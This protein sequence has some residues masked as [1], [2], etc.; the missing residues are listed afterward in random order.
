VR[1]DSR[2]TLSAAT[3]LDEYQSQVAYFGR[4]GHMRLR[5]STV[6][7]V[8]DGRV[9]HVISLTLAVTGVGRLIVVDPQRLAPTDLNR[10][11][12]A[13]PGDVGR[14]KVDSTAGLLDGR[15]YLD[16]VPIIG[17]AEQL[18]AVP[19]A[20]G[21]DLVV[22][23]CNTISA[24][25]AVAT[26]AMRQKIAHVS[27][28]VADGR[29]RVGG[30]VLT[31][32][33]R[34]SKLACPACFLDRRAAPPRDESLLAPVT[35]LVACLAA[36]NVVRVLSAGRRFC[37]DANCIAVDL[38]SMTLDAFRTLRRADCRACAPTRTTTRQEIA[39]G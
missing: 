36:W 30:L 19:D 21:A 5:K 39:R 10:C 38:R 26:F 25:M 18:D 33:P 31:W 28:A 29:A 12:M 20:Q 22:S 9:G 13:R 16:V 15:P 24:R 17:R 37:L 34:F 32:S 4:R 27:A 2:A 6:L 35:S 23:A 8:G 1:L 3:Y 7:V 11:P 14:W